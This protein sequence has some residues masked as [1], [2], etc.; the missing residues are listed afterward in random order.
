MNL[1]VMTS[2]LLLAGMAVPSAFASTGEIKFTGSISNVTCSVS[3]GTP[4]TDDPNFTV[5][6]GPVSAADLDTVG[7]IAGVIGFRVYIGK[8]GEATCPDGTKVWATFENGATVDPTTG[9][10]VVTPGTGSATGVQ[11]RLFDKLNAPID[12]LGNS[13]NEGV[14][15]TVEDNQAILVY[16]AG[17]QA[18]GPVAAGKADSS[19]IY[20]V[21]YES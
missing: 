9:A 8:A 6:I 19:V 21:R 17:Y 15:E 20:T 11:I 2:A 1:K 13:Q 18:V 5:D 3:G 16:A 7:D 14:K 4:G 12:I 10:L